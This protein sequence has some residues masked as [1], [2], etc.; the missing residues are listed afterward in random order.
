LRFPLAA[1]GSKEEETGLEVVLEQH[2]L[3]FQNAGSAL[4]TA[5]VEYCHVIDKSSPLYCKWYCSLSRFYSYVASFLVFKLMLVSVKQ[6]VY[7]VS[8]YSF[9]AKELTNIH[10]LRSHVVTC[11]CVRLNLVIES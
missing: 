4:L 2:D 5:P 11:D 7:E 3:V 6:Q 8:N 10:V 1:A 9:Y